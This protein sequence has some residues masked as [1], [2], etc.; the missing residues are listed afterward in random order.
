MKDKLKKYLLPNLPYLFFVYLFDKLCQAVRLAPGLDVSE[1]LLHIGQGFQTAFASSAPS[2]HVLDICVGI[3]GAILVRLAVY[4]KAKNAKKYRRGVEY[5]SARWGRPEDI[6]PYID[7]VP[8]WNIPLTRTESLTMTSRPKQPKYARNKNILVIGGSG[9]GK[10]RFFVKPS[11]MQMHSSYVIT[12]P[13]GQLLKETGKMLLHGAPKLD[14]NG[15]PVRDSRGKVIYEPYRIKVLNTINFSKS[16]K[17]NPLAYVRSEKDILKLVNVIIANT[18]GDGEKSSED[19]W[20]KA[21]RLLYCALIGYIWYEA[22]PEERNFITLLDLLNA[23]EARE[24]DETYKSPVDILFDELAQAQPE[25]FA[26]KQYVKFKMAA[27]KTL[28]S[29]LVSCGARLAPFDIKEL[30]DIMTEDELELD[31]MGDRKTA[32]FLIMSDTDITFNFVIAMLQSQLF[33]LLCDKADDFYN[34][35]LPIHVRLILDEFANIGQIP[36]FDKLIATIRSREISASIILQSQSQLKTI[37]KDAADTIVG[38]CDSTLFLGGKEKGTLKEISE[39]LGKET[40]DSLS[41]S[42]NRGAQTSHGLSYQKL[43]KEL[44]TQDEIAVMDGGKCILQLRGVRPFFSDKFDITKHP[45]YQYLSD[46]D[47]RNVFDVERYMKRKPAIV[48]PD[49]PFDMYELNASD[50][51]PDNNNSTKR[52][53]K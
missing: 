24:D 48:K 41:Q 25:H 32:L 5:G 13:K 46:A 12:D 23:C 1:K 22:E 6:A 53:E 40:I 21:E 14:E 51:E 39:L 30:R 10:T 17:Y 38:N 2:F 20:V 26:V 44:M 52:K 42:E 45:R 35:R 43:G 29:I 36:N 28:K 16:M 15:K 47:K 11:I 33:N 9:S 34:G 7:P 4:L 49:E 8:D 50:L 19:F 18:K 37:Y 3:F 31:T 27:G